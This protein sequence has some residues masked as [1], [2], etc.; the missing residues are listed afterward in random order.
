MT[1]GEIKV[2]S[3]GDFGVSFFGSCSF[4][5]VNKEQCL[6]D[7]CPEKAEH[8]SPWVSVRSPP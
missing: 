5:A 7:L 1:F 6:L 8:L 2:N 4:L 3:E